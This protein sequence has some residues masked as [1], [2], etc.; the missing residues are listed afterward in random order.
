MSIEFKSFVLDDG[1]QVE[2]NDADGWKVLDANGSIKG[3]GATGPAGPAGDLTVEE[4][5]GAPSVASVT[6]LK[7]AQADGLAVT[8]EGGGVVRINFTGAGGG[9]ST[10]DLEFLAWVL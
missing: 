2:W 5:D 10:I 9:L 1:D 7:F 4:V 6:K 8:D 3:V